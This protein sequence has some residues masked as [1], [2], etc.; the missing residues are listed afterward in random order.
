MRL[1]VRDDRRM[2]QA[3]VGAA[4]L[5]GTSGC[6]FVKPRTCSLGDHGL[7]PRHVR[8]R[9]VGRAGGAVTTDSGTCPSESTVLGGPVIGSIVQPRAASRSVTVPVIRRA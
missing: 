3:E 8:P 5:G 9:T 2:G 1:Q 4:L 7:G 6:S